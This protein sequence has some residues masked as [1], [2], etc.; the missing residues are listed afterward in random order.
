MYL[1]FGL[2]AI[3]VLF[4]SA[5]PVRAQAENFRSDYTVDYYLTDNGSTI[6]TQ[7]SYKVKITN[8]TASLIINEFT[9]QF[10]KSFQIGNIKVNDDYG[11]VIPKVDN[12]DGKHI[13]TVKLS[14]PQ[15]GLNTSNNLYL[16]FIQYNLF[17]INGNVWEVILPTI[18]NRSGQG[19]YTV[20]VHLPPGTHKKIS[21][22]KPRPDN[23]TINDIVWK[24]PANKTIYA[25]FGDE[26]NYSLELRYHLN[27]PQLTRVYTDIA[28]PPD[29]ENQKVFVNSIEPAP[30]SIIVDEDGNYLGRYFLNPKEEKTI[31]FKGGVVVYAN[32]R[33]DMRTPVSE[34]FS[35]QKRYLLATSKDW[36]LKERQIPARVNNIQDIYD[37]TVKT[38]TYNYAR[39]NTNITRLG[40]SQ[41]LTYPDQAVCTEF[42][43]V[44]I[45][46]SRENGIYTRELQGFG[47]SNDQDLRPL[48]VN[49]DILHSWSE[50][51]DTTASLWHQLDPTWENTSGID[52]F[53]SFDLNHI[54]FAIHGKDPE[55]PYPA[56]SYK[57]NDSTKDINIAATADTFQEKKN[58]SF[59]ISP[60]Q[61]PGISSNTFNL[62]V[63][64]KNTGNTFLWDLPLSIMG[65]NLSFTNATVSTIVLAPYETKE[66]LFEY[67][68]AKFASSSRITIVSGGQPVFSQ[69][70]PITSSYFTI[71]KIV[72]YFTG[73]IIVIF[74]LV[75]LFKR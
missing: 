19:D 5:M 69:Q 6:G 3:F 11:E 10:P 30:S 64:V 53:H 24:N 72:L 14:N 39:V 26:Q 8:L 54:V 58:L 60:I 31:Y 12:T 47:F 43:D 44:L 48:S 4:G 21:I 55:Y 73:V 28:L 18:D 61:I 38:L 33:D 15:A 40:A 36:L 27:N 65:D 63:L 49:A 66:L 46:L 41:A 67:T 57:T 25:V 9:L 51:Y 29:T 13:I 17:K 2:L 62:K 74:F 7:V 32:P 71:L 75:K 1:V 52:Y 23:V 37:Y 70:V 16:D 50:F 45:A 56:G 42:S 20:N 59:Q 68:P 35:Q 22:A 34:M